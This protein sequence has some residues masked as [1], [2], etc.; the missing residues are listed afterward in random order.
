MDAFYRHFFKSVYYLLAKSYTDC[1]AANYYE[2]FVIIT[3]F[4]RN[5]SLKITNFK[6]SAQQKKG[7]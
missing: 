4:F 2:F 7:P 1:I 6:F 5:C 3:I